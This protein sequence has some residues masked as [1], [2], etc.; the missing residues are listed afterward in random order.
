[1]SAVRQPPS[2]IDGLGAHV[3]AAGGVHLAPAR[4][5]EIGATALQ[6][7]TKSP[8]Q[9]LE[10]TVSAEDALTFRKAVVAERIGGVVAHD[11]YLINLASPDSALRT[12]SIKAFIAELTRCTLLGVDGLVSHPGNYL[13]DR[14]RGLRANAEAYSRCLGAVPGRVMLLIETT[15]GT[16]TGL[17]SR[18][19]ELGELRDRI[20]AAV[21]SRVAFCADTCHLFA[22]GYDLK[23]DFDGVWSEWD[24]VIGLDL[25]RCLHLNDSMTPLGSRRDRHAWI[26]KGTL[27]SEP[28]RRIMTDPRFR[29]VPKILEPPKSDREQADTRRVLG[30][31]RRYA[32]GARR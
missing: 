22:A 10:R 4:A 26:G 11:S 20:D 2:S 1:M 28:F 30:R 21:R 32:R 14:A 16:G 12:R 25:L 13:D 5:R 18:F 8:N 15:A 6:L 9:W 31:L 3:S 7:F 27:G 17:G 29:E 24:R 23:G 19:E